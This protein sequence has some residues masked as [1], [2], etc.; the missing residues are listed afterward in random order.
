MRFTNKSAPEATSAAPRSSGAHGAK[1]KCARHNGS[2]TD[3][4]SGAASTFAM[5]PAKV[6]PEANSASNGAHGIVAESVV[7]KLMAKKR[8]PRD[9]IRSHHSVS[10]RPSQIRPAVAATESMNE[11]SNAH[12]GSSSA[13][14]NVDRPKVRTVSGLRPSPPA[15]KETE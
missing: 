1:S 5:R 2:A 6:T 8:V 10:G 3:S 15:N 7:A 13:N 14:T 9:S 12:S 11:R 4:P